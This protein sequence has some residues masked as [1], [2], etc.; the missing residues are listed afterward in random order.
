MRGSVENVRR[1]LGRLRAAMT[2]PSPRDID[3]TLPVLAQAMA[4]LEET[5]RKLAI[6]ETP[7]RGLGAELAALS[8]EIVLAQQLAERGLELYR[9]R[10]RELAALAGGYGATGLPAPLPTAA[11]IQIEG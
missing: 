6:G 1:H 10:A 5:E 2:A 4:F 3:D 8:R 9:G 7:Q 11:T